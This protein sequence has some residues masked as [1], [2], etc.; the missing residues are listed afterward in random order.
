MVL[1]HF[2]YLP[3]EASRLFLLSHTLAHFPCSLAERREIHFSISSVV[4]TAL[5][6]R[7]LCA[8]CIQCISIGP[9]NGPLLHFLPV[10]GAWTCFNSNPRASIS[11]SRISFR[12]SSPRDCLL[13]IVQPSS[14]F[15]FNHDLTNRRLADLRQYATPIPEQWP[16][17]LNIL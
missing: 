14:V 7:E 16:I 11:A 15:L 3:L 4:A 9:N 8:M 6:I 2:K 1:R 13:I 5:P 17:A 10:S 12:F